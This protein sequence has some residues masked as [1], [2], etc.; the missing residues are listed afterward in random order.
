MATVTVPV[1]L[2][3]SLTDEGLLSQE[4]FNQ[5]MSNIL[6]P[7]M[8]DFEEAADRRLV[9]HETICEL[10]VMVEMEEID[11]GIDS[12]EALVAVLRPISEVWGD[13]P[14]PRPSNRLRYRDSPKEDEA[15]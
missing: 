1:T 10:D 15:E 5:L 12:G 13:G 9:N 7:L 2:S 8:E 11:A 6:G 4:V 14:P 3:I